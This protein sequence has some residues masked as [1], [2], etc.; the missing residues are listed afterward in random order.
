MSRTSRRLGTAAAFAVV[1]TF[2]SI[3]IPTSGR[4]FVSD[5]FEWALSN[6]IRSPGDLLRVFTRDNGFF[7]PVVALTFGANEYFAGTNPKSYGVT[8]VALAIVASV[9]IYCLAVAA[10]LPRGGGIFAAAVWL[11]NFHGINMAVLWISGRTALLVTI[12]AAAAIAAL[13]RG[14]MRLA[15]AMYALAV[16]SK[17]E[18][19][20]LPIVGAVW[21]WTFISPEHRWRM[22]LRWSAGCLVIT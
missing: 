18:A 8:N 20:L 5:D 14:R 1:V 10:G 13:L 3:Y 7:R 17:E 6:R 4:G 2:L 21:L 12:G 11:L 16:L 15:L 9:T 19:I 22:L